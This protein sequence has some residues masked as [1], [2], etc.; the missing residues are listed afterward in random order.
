MLGSCCLFVVRW[1]RITS[2]PYS[3]WQVL[4]TGKTNVAAKCNDSSGKYLQI[5]LVFLTKPFNYAQLYVQLCTAVKHCRTPTM[6]LDLLKNGRIHSG[7]TEQASAHCSATPQWP[8]TVWLRSV[9]VFCLPEHLY[10]KFSLCSIFGTLGK[11]KRVPSSRHLN[12]S[13]AFFMF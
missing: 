6:R 8:Y 12:S 7:S 11:R 5:P 10:T 13:N 2:S 4:V 1:T 3:H 9:A